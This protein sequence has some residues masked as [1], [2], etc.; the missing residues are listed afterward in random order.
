MIATN[1]KLN[2][3]EAWSAMVVN[4]KL[5]FCVCLKLINYFLLENKVLEVF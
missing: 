2:T 4:Q 5:F 3:L 1:L